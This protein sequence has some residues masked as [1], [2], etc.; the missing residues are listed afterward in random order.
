MLLAILIAAIP[1]YG[2]MTAPSASPVPGVRPAIAASEALI[3]KSNSTNTA[4][5]LLRVYVDG[6]TTLQQGDIPLQ[7]HVAMALVRRFF[8]DLHAAGPVDR[9]A[10]RRCMKRR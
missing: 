7:K 8:A 3:V 5:Y 6:R 10:A 9:I 2:P 4:G 1:L